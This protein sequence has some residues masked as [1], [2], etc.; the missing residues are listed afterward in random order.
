VSSLFD[1]GTSELADQRH[2]KPPS[3]TKRSGVVI[4]YSLPHE[5]ENFRFILTNLKPYGIE[6]S[7]RQ[8]R[9]FYRNFI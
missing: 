9:D 1:Y 8:E 5:N 2:L 6:D 4:F 7:A 3:S